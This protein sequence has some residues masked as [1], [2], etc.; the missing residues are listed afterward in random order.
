MTSGLGL[1]VLAIISASA[2]TTIGDYFTET[3]AICGI[4]GIS[5]RIGK[6]DMLGYVY[7]IYI[8]G[9]VISFFGFVI[10]LNKFFKGITQIISSNNI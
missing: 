6:S 10:L 1:F 4:H 2:L 9:L 8:S 7:F 3:F 5:V